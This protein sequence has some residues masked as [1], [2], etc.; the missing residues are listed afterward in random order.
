MGSKNDVHG[1]KIGG[2]MRGGHMAMRPFVKILW[3]VVIIL[4]IINKILKK[5]PLNKIIT[6]HMPESLLSVN[7]KIKWQTLCMTQNVTLVNSIITGDQ[8]MPN[9]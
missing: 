3:P 6:I 2:I 7:I 4:F 8:Q 1:V 5:L 9:K